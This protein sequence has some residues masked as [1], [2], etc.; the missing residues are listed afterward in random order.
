MSSSLPDF[1]TVVDTLNVKPGH[2]NF[3][4]LDASP[5]SS[6]RHFEDDYGVSY[7]DEKLLQLRRMALEARDGSVGLGD[8]YDAI[9]AHNSLY[10]QTGSDGETPLLEIANENGVIVIGKLIGVG[11]N[12]TASDEDLVTF[13]EDLDNILKRNGVHVVK[14]RQEFYPNRPQA[15]SEGVDKF[16][17]MHEICAQ[18]DVLTLIEPEIMKDH[19]EF[20]THA[21]LQLDVLRRIEDGIRASG[22][23]KHPRFYKTSIAGAEQ[24]RDSFDAA[25]WARVTVANALSAGIYDVGKVVRLSG[26]WDT[27]TMLAVQNEIGKQVQRITGAYDGASYARAGLRSAVGVLFEDA[28]SPN[29]AAGAHELLRTGLVT[30]AAIAGRLSEDIKAEESLTVIQEA[31]N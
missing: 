25:E 18:K 16:V 24:S 28:Q 7:S 13:G 9:I 10:D 12:G 4:A 26:G 11:R 14:L 23:A 1:E 8:V 19:G 21:D 20:Y 6:R 31:L 27:D 29:F 22:A 15:T 17:K 30:R 3:L 2:R 5:S